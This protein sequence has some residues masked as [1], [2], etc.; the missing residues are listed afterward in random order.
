VKRSEGDGEGRKEGRKEG[1]REGGRRRRKDG[2]KGKQTS[3]G[4]VVD[5]K[6]A[7]DC[8]AEAERKKERNP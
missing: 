3:S 2:R 8:G 6:L 4:L 5:V 1:G 7:C